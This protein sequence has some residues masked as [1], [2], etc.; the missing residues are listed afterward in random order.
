MSQSVDSD[1]V[2]VGGGPAG[3]V[4]A[5]TVATGGRRA[6]VVEREQTIGRPVH[7]SGGTTLGTVRSLGVPRQL[8]HPL[9]AVQF[10]SRRH[11][12]S[13]AFSEP[14]L[15]MLDV[16]GVYQ[17]LARRAQDAGAEVRTGHHAET[18]MRGASGRVEGCTVRGPGDEPVTVRAPVVVDAGGYRSAMSRQV[19]LHPGF[20]RFGVGA[21]VDVYAPHAD[22]SGGVVVLDSR[23]APAGYGWAVPLGGSRLRIGVGVHHP[24][25]RVRP[26]DLLRR[27]LADMPCF[28][29]DLTGSDVLDRHFG[30]IPV[31]P[32]PSRL[33]ADGLLAV[34]DAAAQATLV[35]GEG[36]RMGAYAGQLAGRTVLAAH[37]QRRFDAQTLGG[38]ERE[39]RARKGRALSLGYALNTRIAAYGDDEWDRA[40]AHLGHVP[41]ATLATLV[42]SEFTPFSL[43]VAF[44]RSPRLWPGLARLVP[45]MVATQVGRSRRVAD[46][47]TTG[48]GG[49]GRDLV[50]RTSTALAG[51]EPPA[52]SAPPAGSETPPSPQVPPPPAAPGGRKV[53]ERV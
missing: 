37:E 14:A 31:E 34:G 23:Y 10:F 29:L 47:A 1:V 24:D 33:V 16:T 12:A 8:Y 40:V 48:H 39:F 51:S 44:L 13:F 22:D 36:I 26:A 9:T 6:V 52:G 35:I 28:G 18:L 7:T 41:S 17:F 19:G 4:T 15:C 25:V 2:V 32:L 3:L 42:L 21:E 11:R 49:A 5:A 20:R 30:L 45:T 43:A 38:Y 27:F 50:S 53:P 46:R